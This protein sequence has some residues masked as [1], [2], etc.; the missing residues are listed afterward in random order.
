MLRS[1]FDESGGKAVRSM[2]NEFTGTMTVL[3][4]QAF[5]DEAAADVSAGDAAD[6]L[7]A[8][9]SRTFAEILARFS[10]DAGT[11]DNLV[12]ELCADDPSRN[13]ASMDKKVKG[14]LSGKYQPTAREDLL[15]L[16]FVLK[17]PVDQAD[18]FLAAAGE[19][20]LHWRDPKELAY[21]FALRKGM[22]YPEAVSLYGRVAPGESAGA[23]GAARDSFTSM[24]RREA[25]RLETEEELKLYLAG[26]KET[27]G[28]YHNTAYRQLT[29]YL[30]LL[31]QPRAVSVEEEESFTIRRIVE[32][33]LDNH[34]PPDWDKKK[35]DEKRRGILAGWPDEI[36]LSRMKTGKTD[37]NRK[38]LILLF[39]ATDGG[40]E[41]TDD[42]EDDVYW[43][44][45]ENESDEAADFRSSY[46]RMNR[47]LSSCGYRMLDPRNPFDWVVIYCMRVGSDPESME[48]L[49]ERLSDMLDVL[50][51][52]SLP[53]TE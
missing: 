15:E 13:R 37:V 27:L 18:A 26:A 32:T 48:G 4:Q 30:S 40:D 14:W 11:R 16:C 50:F 24:V 36:T 28:A 2:D 35:L 44:E 9:P 25:D 47:M 23:D 53:E 51:S 12:K 21:A 42:W 22:S 7:L 43:D 1:V 38:T 33:Y 29:E 46:I 39:L 3:S 6:L 41:I 45:V 49:N 10:P 34:F 19:E 8:V 5:D 31:E 17:L 52:A 20:G